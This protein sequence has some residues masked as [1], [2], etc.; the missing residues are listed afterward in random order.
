MAYVCAHAR[1]YVPTVHPNVGLFTVNVSFSSDYE[2]NADER[3]C[4]EGGYP[5]A[6][7]MLFDG[8][9]LVG[10]TSGKGVEQSDALVQEIR[11]FQELKHDHI[12]TFIG[13]CSYGSHF[14]LCT[15]YATNGSLYNFLH[16]E[17]NE[18]A[19]QD[20]RRWG[21]EIARGMQFL[22]GENTTVPQFEICPRVTDGSLT[23]CF[24]SLHP[25]IR[26]SMLTCTQ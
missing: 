6:V 22:V 2:G 12:I 7:K 25:A 16:K 17:S 11:L 10:E 13:A 20:A 9:V 19:L 3:A 15:E 21:I 8:D 14:Y 1:V 23:A 24:S 4:N 26:H 5:V 18:Y